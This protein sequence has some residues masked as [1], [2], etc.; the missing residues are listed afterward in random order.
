[1]S[2]VIRAGILSVARGQIEAAYTLG[3]TQ[4]QTIRYI[5]LPQAVRTVLPSLGNEFVTLIKDSSLASIIGVYE[6]TKEGSFIIARSFNS[7]SIYIAI[8]GIYL[9][10]TIPLTLYINYLEKRMRHYVSH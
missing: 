6:L 9:L 5:V 8:A 10:M 2:N 7:I 1:V 3:L 4:L